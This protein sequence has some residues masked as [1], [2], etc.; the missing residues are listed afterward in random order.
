MCFSCGWRFKLSLQH[1]LSGPRR[2]EA[3]R[4]CMRRSRGATADHGWSLVLAV[5]ARVLV[6][7]PHWPRDSGIAE[8]PDLSQGLGR[9]LTWGRVNHRRSWRVPMCPCLRVSKTWR[10]AHC[11]VP[12]PGWRQRIFVQHR[13]TVRRHEHADRILS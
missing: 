2:D 13:W 9:P 4:R 12:L 5:D 3:W 11:Y 8:E 1:R 7:M 6:G 10:W